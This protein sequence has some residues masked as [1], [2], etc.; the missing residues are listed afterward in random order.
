[1]VI[2]VIVFLE[3]RRVSRTSEDIGERPHDRLH[4]LAVDRG[5]RHSEI[6]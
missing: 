6:V 3:Q 2:L 5:I 1:L 4:L